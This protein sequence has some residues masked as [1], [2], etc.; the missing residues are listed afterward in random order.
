MVNFLGLL[1]AVLVAAYTFIY[2]FHIWRTERNFLGAL[3]LGVLGL[4]TIAL[5]VYLLYLRG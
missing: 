2:A 3:V 1:L 4:G 5:P